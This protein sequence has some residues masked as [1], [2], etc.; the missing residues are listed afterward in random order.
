MECRPSVQHLLVSLREKTSV[1]TCNLTYFSFKD[2]NLFDFRANSLSCISLTPVDYRHLVFV[3]RYCNHPSY[4]IHNKPIVDCVRM[5]NFITILNL[6]PE[7]FY[8]KR[9]CPAFCGKSF[10]TF[11]SCHTSLSTLVGSTL[12]PTS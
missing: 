6:G 5:S 12:S 7:I 9:V 11:A 8:C 2:Y 1:Y 10:I 4:L 3:F